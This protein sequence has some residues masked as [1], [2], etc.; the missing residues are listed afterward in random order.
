MNADRSDLF[1]ARPDARVGRIPFARN[2]IIGQ[3]V[4]ERLL[5]LSEVPVKVLAMPLEIYDWIPDQLPRSVK[6]HVAATL[7]LEQ[8]DALAL[9][10]LG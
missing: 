9:Q 2:S 5:D 8:L 10:K 1:P 6:R 3:S 7:D 4:D